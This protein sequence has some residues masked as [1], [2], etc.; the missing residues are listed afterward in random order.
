MPDAEQ[1]MEH[2]VR[3]P[4][5]QDSA[6]TVQAPAEFFD[7]LTG[8][9]I[10]EPVKLM[11]STHVSHGQTFDRR[12]LQHW[13]RM[14]PGAIRCSVSVLLA[15]HRK[16]LPSCTSLHTGSA[17]LTRSFVVIRGGPPHRRGDGRL[18]HHQF[19]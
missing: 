5:F 7:R 19:R 2:F 10:T 14:Y 6:L 13:F 4:I 12:S 1:E 3:G 18:V 17:S 9:L 8:C 16:V 11:R 15:Q